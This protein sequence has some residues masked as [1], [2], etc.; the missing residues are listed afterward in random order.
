LS[1]TKLIFQKPAKH[2]FRSI[3]EQGVEEGFV[4]P[5][6]IDPEYKIPPEPISG[7]KAMPYDEV[8]KGGSGGIT[9]RSVRYTGSVRRDRAAQ[10]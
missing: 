2:L 10:I 4:L 7:I 1:S 3:A 5:V 8:A 9:R 6:A